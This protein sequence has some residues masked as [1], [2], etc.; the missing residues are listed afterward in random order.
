[1]FVLGIETYHANLIIN[2]Q[3]SKVCL[4]RTNNFATFVRKIQMKQSSIILFVLA[5]LALVSCKDRQTGSFRPV[6]LVGQILSDTSSVPYRQLAKADSPNVHGT[7][8]VVGAPEDAIL[9][10]EYLVSYDCHN[11]ISG[12]HTEDG[13][14]DFSGETFAQILDE[15][16]SPY[17]D[18]LSQDESVLLREANVLNF[19]MAVDTTCLASPYDTTGYLYKQRSKIVI[20]ASSESSSYGYFDIDTLCKSTGTDIKIFAP[21][22]AMAEYAA[23]RHGEQTNIAVWSVA[24]KIS[25][26]VYSGYKAFAPVSYQDTTVRQSFLRFL[27]MYIDSGSGKRLDAMFLDDNSVSVDELNGVID[28]I[29]S[30]DNDNLL[31]YKNILDENFECIHPGKALAEKCYDYLRKANAFTHRISYPEVR[32]FITSSV[33]SGRNA[34]VELRD[35][36]FSDSL[37]DFMEQN[38]PKTFSLYVR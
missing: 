28:E 32:F 4:I 21:V 2:S 13:L 34:L 37:M 5:S 38:A 16:Q 31:I 36:Y 6:S 11:N 24:D 14:P 29:V 22:Q 35:K 30:T 17:G 12:K 8:A 3:N 1:M 9:V 26:G 23:E 20:M 10:T 7:I 15:A 25:N 27:D 33:P 19:L 18:F